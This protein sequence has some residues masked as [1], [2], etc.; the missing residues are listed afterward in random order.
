MARRHSLTPAIHQAVVTAV[1]GGVPYYQDM[2]SIS[3]R[4]Q[5][6]ICGI[7]RH[8]KRVL[9]SAVNREQDTHHTPH[10]GGIWLSK[11]LPHLPQA[12]PGC[13]VNVGCILRNPAVGCAVP[14]AMSN[15]LPVG[16][17]TRQNGLPSGTHAARTRIGATR[18][19][20]IVAMLNTG[21]SMA[22]IKA[23]ATP[24]PA[25]IMPPMQQKSALARKQ[26]VRPILTNTTSGATPTITQILRRVAPISVT[27]N[28][29]IRYALRHFGGLR[30]SGAQSKILVVCFCSGKPGRCAAVPTD[31]RF[32]FSG[33]RRMPLLHL[34][35]GMSGVSI[36]ES[37]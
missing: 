1:A 22:N 36:V 17:K 21:R 24:L 19:I 30:T 7:I 3:G 31:R 16:T 26:I 12:L 5:R 18:R 4:T 14:V 35:G 2:Q 10:G 9:F 15:I 28:G 13:V 6:R 33:M 32:P 11:N 29:R 37:R 27:G 25:S 8:F 34:H 23:S 20:G